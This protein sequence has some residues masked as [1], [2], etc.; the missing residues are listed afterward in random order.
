MKK[1]ANKKNPVKSAIRIS[2]LVLVSLII[3]LNVYT[4]NA[5]RIAGDAIPMPLGVGAAVVLSGSMEPELSVGDLLI[6]AQR[7][8]YHVGDVVVYQDGTLAVTHRIVTVTGDEV[9]TQGDA[10]NTPDRPI[11]MKQLKGGVVLAIPFLGYAVNAIKT[12]LGTLCILAL[13]I[14]LLERSFH[15]EKQKDAEELDAIRAE[16]ERLKMQQNNP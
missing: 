15:A 13:A 10:N 14:F 7:K 16:I 6:V 12:P 4:I 5:S 8:N 3:G 1:A 9:I 2:L 11:T